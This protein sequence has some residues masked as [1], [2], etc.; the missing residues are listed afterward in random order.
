MN[1]GRPVLWALTGLAGLLPA[2][3]SA[4]MIVDT[5]PAPTLGFEVE[6]ESLS[7]VPLPGALGLL[8]SGIAA[9]RRHFVLR[10]I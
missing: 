7:A 10:P 4:E 2:I 8:A 1:H 3:T 6:G 5:G 9:L